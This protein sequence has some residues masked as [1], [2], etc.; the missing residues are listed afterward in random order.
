MHFSSSVLVAL[1]ATASAIDIRAYQADGCNGSTRSCANINPN[2]CCTF[3]QDAGMA[4]VGFAAIPTNWRIRCEAYTE[5][6]CSSFGGQGDSNGAGFVCLPF[7]TR[8]NRTGGK[9]WFLNRK[10]AIEDTCPAEQADGGKCTSSV[11]YNTV[12]LAD[13]T[14][15]NITG[16]SEEKVQ[17]LEKLA[18]SGASADAIPVEF[19]SFRR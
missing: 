1:A 15:Y 2:V 9:Y 6:G 7:T 5:G 19:H 16:L 11:K 12:G 8:G 10:R 18:D 14:E 4:S 17:E 3:P 13:G